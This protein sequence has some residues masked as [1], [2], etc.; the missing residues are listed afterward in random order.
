[1]PEGPNQVENEPVP[2][3]VTEL[4][5]VEWELSEVIRRLEVLRD[6]VRELQEGA[7]PRAAEEEIHGAL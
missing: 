3:I 4:R 6:H 1:M 7:T 2:Q 5:A